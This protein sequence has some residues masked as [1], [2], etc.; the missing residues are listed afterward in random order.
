MK[1]D[2]VASC[3]IFSL[4]GKTLLIQHPKL[5]KWLPPGGHTEENELPHETAVREALE[6]TGLHVRLYTTSPIH[7]EESNARSIPAPFLCLLEEI[8]AFK[9]TPAHQH[10][11]M[12]YI[13]TVDMTAQ[14]AL[15]FSKESREIC[16]W[17]SWEDIASLQSEIDIFN[18]TK[19]I[20]KY[21]FTNYCSEMKCR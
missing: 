16:Q 10:I 8:P 7:V 17:F 1:R 15:A 12:V 19:Q 9:E 6:E 2:F 13:G 11:D 5:Q 21:L 14:E 20:L 18:E 3:Y 4:D